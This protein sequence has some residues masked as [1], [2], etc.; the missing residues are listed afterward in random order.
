MSKHARAR[1]TQT[2]V[3]SAHHRAPGDRQPPSGRRDIAASECPRAHRSCTWQLSCTWILHT[4]VPAPTAY[5]MPAGTQASFMHYLAEKAPAPTAYLMP[6]GR[7]PHTSVALLLCFVVAH[8]ASQWRASQGAS[9]CPQ[10]QM[11]E[12]ARMH[13][14]PNAPP[15]Q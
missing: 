14:H 11:K 12:W 13:R 15:L 9:Q 3:S 8:S 10:L 4:K 5:L 2:Q 1:H 6:A 7:L